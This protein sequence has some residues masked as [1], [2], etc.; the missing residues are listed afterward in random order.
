MPVRDHSNNWESGV[1]TMSALSQIFSSHWCLGFWPAVELTWV[2]TRSNQKAPKTTDSNHS[3]SIIF[4]A[5]Q[6]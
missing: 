6:V 4:G 3:K 1:L 2:Y 5:F